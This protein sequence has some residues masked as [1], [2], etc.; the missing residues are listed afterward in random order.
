MIVPETPSPKIHNRELRPFDL[1]GVGVEV[2]GPPG[3][4][5][6]VCGHG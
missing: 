1:E 6:P 4:S 2:C 3:N 5:L